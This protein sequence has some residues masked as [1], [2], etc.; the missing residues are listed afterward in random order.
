MKLSVKRITAFIAA[1]CCGVS[2]CFTVFGQDA[3]M[4]Y[5]DEYG[6]QNSVS[7]IPSGAVKISVVPSKDKLNVGDEFYVD[8]VLENNPGFSAFGFTV[9]FDDTVI[10][11][12]KSDVGEAS[13]AVEVKYN[14]NINAVSVDGINEAIDIS[15]AKSPFVYTNFLYSGG[16]V[17]TSNDNGILFRVKF[18]A[19]SSGTSEINLSDR[20]NVI[21]STFEGENILTYVQNASVTVEGQA[22]Q[23]T[24]SSDTEDNTET[25]TSKSDET[26]TEETETQDEIETEEETEKIADDN[27]KKENTTVTTNEFTIKLPTASLGAKEF[28]DMDGAVWAKDAVLRLSSLGIITGVDDN[29]FNPKANTSRADFVVVIS[30]LLGLDADMENVF[31]DVDSGAYYEKAV[32][33]ANG[34]DLVQG[35]DGKFMP[36]NNITRQDAMVILSRIL[37]KAGKAKD[38]D[39]NVLN[40]FV[41][42]NDISSYAV[43][44]VARLVEAGVV[45]GDDN[46]R[47]NPKG[48]ITRAEMAVII[49][50]VYDI[51]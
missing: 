48:F 4:L 23:K 36:K 15:E 32:S 42:K 26:E 18:R 24:E 5:F 9:A 46:K 21:L 3:G 11:P 38:T 50:K 34:F 44:P 1:I 39:E 49:D 19:I 20:L 51:L 13:D 17:G 12:F 27:N 43:L 29:T 35:F 7:S 30:R 16:D 22:A 40:G 33:R 10:E 25:T 41:D 37:E 14:G 47:L 6:D 28:T 45:N 8:F 2:F 31:S